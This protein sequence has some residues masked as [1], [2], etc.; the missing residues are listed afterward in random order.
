MEHYVKRN[1][2]GEI[3][4][5]LFNQFQKEIQSACKESAIDQYGVFVLNGK[6]YELEY[7][8][9]NVP[10]RISVD[11]ATEKFSENAIANG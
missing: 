4:M 6:R 5:V 3:V 7:K 8:A 9:D 1:D 10:W 11:D 2:D